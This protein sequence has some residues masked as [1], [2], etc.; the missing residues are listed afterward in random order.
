MSP[1]PRRNGM[2]TPDHSSLKDCGPAL[3]HG[4]FWSQW[5]GA[6]S[7]AVVRS[8]IAMRQYFPRRPNNDWGALGVINIDVAFPWRGRTVYAFAEYFHNDFGVSELP[9]P[10][11][12]LPA[13]CRPVWNTASSSI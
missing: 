1:A 5:T 8:D 4:I 2:A 6:G 9:T 12:S 3:R 10:L 13:D 7:P 11:T